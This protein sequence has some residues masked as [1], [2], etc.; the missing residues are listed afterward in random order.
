MTMN[1]TFLGE[2]RANTKTYI[3]T[4]VTHI[5]VGDDSTTPTPTDSALGN[6]TFIDAVDDTDTSQTGK[7]VMSLRIATTENNGNDIDEV[8]AFDAASGGNLKSR[9]VIT[10]ISKTSDIQ[11]Y[12]DLEYETRVTEVDSFD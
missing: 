2:I 10:T 7:A 11:V 12:I 8:A 1:S 6:E 4:E 3:S 5:G 9:D